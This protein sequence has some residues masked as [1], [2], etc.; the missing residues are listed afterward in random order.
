[1]PLAIMEGGLF[2]QLGQPD[3]KIVAAKM[4]DMF[5]HCNRI[6]IPV[7]DICD[8]PHQKVLDPAACCVN[9]IPRSALNYRCSTRSFE[10]AFI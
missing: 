7:S 10:S 4:S 2:M 9:I 5:R 3:M 8:G 1:M 6:S